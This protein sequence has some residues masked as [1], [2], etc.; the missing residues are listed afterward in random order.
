MRRRQVLAL[1]TGAA[2]A[3]PLRTRAQ[4]APNRRVAILML[5]AEN[6]PQGQ[7]RA[8]AFKLG[9]E[10]AGWTPG[11]NITVDYIWAFNR[12]GRTRSRPSCAGWRLT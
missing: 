2:A 1:M 10:S 7:A 5:Y 4:P 8:A 9:L 3:L 12:I 11:R 6:D